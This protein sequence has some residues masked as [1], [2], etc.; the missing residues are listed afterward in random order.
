MHALCQPNVL[1]SSAVYVPV[2]GSTIMKHIG[3]VSIC[4]TAIGV[5]PHS[6]TIWEAVG[7][8]IVDVLRN[9][10]QI[11]TVVLAVLAVFIDPTTAGIGDSAQALTYNAPKKDK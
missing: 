2:S 7:S 6:F 9:P 3:I 8:C 11:V 1:T 10:V 5:D 4:I